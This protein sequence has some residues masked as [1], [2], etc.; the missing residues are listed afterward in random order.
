MC[1]S[2]DPD[3]V[4]QIPRLD[5]VLPQDLCLTEGGF[6]CVSTVIDTREGKLPLSGILLLVS[7]LS[8][9]IVNVD[10][11]ETKLSCLNFVVINHSLI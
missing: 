9:N 6:Y 2:R 1:L 10:T 8:S 3:K 7:I 11:A 4:A 5:Y